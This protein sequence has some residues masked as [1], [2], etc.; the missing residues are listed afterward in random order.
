M[1]PSDR[2]RNLTYVCTVL[3]LTFVSVC[4]LT[5]RTETTNAIMVSSSKTLSL[6]LQRVK[7]KK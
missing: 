7:E 6:F 3:R 1:L 5:G 4:T 2:G